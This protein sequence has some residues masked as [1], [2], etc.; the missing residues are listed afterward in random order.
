[1]S[2]ILFEIQTRQGLL[3][4]QVTKTE[5]LGACI[6]WL[7]QMKKLINSLKKWK[8]LFDKKLGKWSYP[9]QFGLVG[10]SGM[11]P[12][13]LSFAILLTFIP[14]G[15]ARGPSIWLAMTW[16]FW[17]N[18]RLTFSYARRGPLVRQYVLYCCSCLAGAMVS[19]STCLGI[20][21]ASGWFRKNE[22]VSAAIGV[23][24]GALVNYLLA[25]HIVFL[26]P[27]PSL[28]KREQIKAP[29]YES[30]ATF[31]AK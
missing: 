28:T 7:S 29:T 15:L 21:L 30:Q 12:D 24:A 4:L 18:R 20:C 5:I 19:W 17:L 2:F 1:M 8:R 3:E 31:L 22:I 6:L 13:L 25:R 16:N 10:L 26:S 14:L 11:I 9:I 23:L 27:Q